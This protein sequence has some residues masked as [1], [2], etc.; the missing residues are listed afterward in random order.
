MAYTGTPNEIQFKQRL[1]RM[2][3]KNELTGKSPYALQWAGTS[4]SGWSF[5][6]FQYDIAGLPSAKSLIQNILKNATSISGSYILDDGN[7]ATTRTSDTEV[8]R[9]YSAVQLRGG[10]GLSSADLTLVNSCIGSDYGR[11][12]LVNS[13]DQYCNDVVL[14]EISAFQSAADSRYSVFL[15]SDMG[16]LFLADFSNQYGTSS[17]ATLRTYFSGGAG[18]SAYA[19]HVDY[20]IGDALQVY[21]RTTN[22]KVPHGMGFV[23]SS[24][25]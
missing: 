1:E 2:V 7:S 8:T 19:T 22:N 9:L 21:V 23:A 24:T 12:A 25:L 20:G 13:Y 11:T 16:K 4:A 17:R 14:P 3:E 18:F 15:S 6:V 5:G 10:Q